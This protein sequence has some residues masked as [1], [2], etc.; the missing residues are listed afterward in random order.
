M[1][2]ESKLKWVLI[3]I[4]LVEVQEAAVDFKCFE[5]VQGGLLV[6]SR[7]IIDDLLTHWVLTTSDAAW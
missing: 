1:L 5:P 2:V 3:G 7:L 4:R 6:I